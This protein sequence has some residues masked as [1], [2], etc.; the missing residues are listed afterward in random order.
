MRPHHR[1]GIDPARGFD[2]TRAAGT[3]LGHSC[4]RS[5][6]WARMSTG[7][8]ARSMC[9][10]R[11]SSRSASPWVPT[12]EPGSGYRCRPVR[13]SAPLGSSS[14]SLGHRLR[15][16]G[17]RRNRT[18]VRSAPDRSWTRDYNLQH[19]HRRP[20]RVARCGGLTSRMRPGQAG[21]S[22]AQ[23]RR[24]HVSDTGTPE[25]EGPEQTDSWMSPKMLESVSPGFGDPPERGPRGLARRR[26]RGVGRT[27]R[28]A[29]APGAT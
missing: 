24:R 20:R 15:A 8:P 27:P 14:S 26:G 2:A 5:V 12:S 3:S 13:S 16:G 9:R 29:Q 11:S 18:S 25:V 17:R 19:A 10:R 22:R 21:G 7:S 23:R 4:C 28:Q 1:P 6:P